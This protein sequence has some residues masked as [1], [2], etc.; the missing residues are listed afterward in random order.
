MSWFF[1]IVV[2]VLTGVLV[3]WLVA[4]ERTGNRHLSSREALRRMQR[5]A[6]R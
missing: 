2:A 1:L 4:H 5:K 6:R 3:H